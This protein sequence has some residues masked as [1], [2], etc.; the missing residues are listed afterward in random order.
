MQAQKTESVTK[1]IMEAATEGKTSE[2]LQNLCCQK[3]NR[4]GSIDAKLASKLIKLMK[5]LSNVPKDKLNEGQN[6]KYL[7][8]DGLLARVNPACVKEGLA[9]VVHN[10]VISWKEVTKKSG[11]VWQLVA[12]RVTITIIDQ[13]TGASITTEGIGMGEDPGDKAFSKAQTQGRKYALM[14]ALNISTGDDPELDEK[15]DH[16][17]EETI[18]CKKCGKKAYFEKMGDND[19]EPVKIYKC[20]ECRAETRAKA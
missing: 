18:A 16:S 7:S 19:G 3:S 1:E 6:Y 4:C 12:T 13:D 5:A 11:M 10:E 20:S 9:T 14:L 15:A 2:Q 17:N 8:S